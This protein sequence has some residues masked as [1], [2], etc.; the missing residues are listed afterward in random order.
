MIPILR[1][2]YSHTFS[3]NPLNAADNFPYGGS[4]TE[5]QVLEARCI[6]KC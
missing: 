6:L 2:T 4:G 1:S 5:I 3:S